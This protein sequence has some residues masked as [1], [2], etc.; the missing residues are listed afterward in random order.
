MVDRRFV[1]S[2][3]WNFKLVPGMLKP[4]FRPSPILAQHVPFSTLAHRPFSNCRSTVLAGAF[5]VARPLTPCSLCAVCR[6][7]CLAFDTLTVKRPLGVGQPTVRQAAT[8]R[9][10]PLS[11]L[12][13]RRRLPTGYGE[14][15]ECALHPIICAI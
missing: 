12:P 2:R 10:I 7:S 8:H 3:F 11:Y 14:V 15:L 4:V 1:Y 6:N 9:D 5:G 13:V